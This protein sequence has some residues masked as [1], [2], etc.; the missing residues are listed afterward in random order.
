MLLCPVRTRIAKPG[1]DLAELIHE[2]LGKLQLEVGD[3]DV[4]ALAS[5]IVSYAQG[6][7]VKL[8][9][10][11]PSKEARN[12]AKKHALESEFAELVLLEAG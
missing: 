2:A 8:S 10:V 3:G 1:D 11:K 12:L 6:L 4:L 7:V 9:D 5:K